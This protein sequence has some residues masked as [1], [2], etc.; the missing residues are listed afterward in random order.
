MTK[1][2]DPQPDRRDDE[3]RESVEEDPRLVFARVFAKHDRWL[4]AYL[5]TLLGNLSHAEEV[6][7]D[8]CVVLWK[9][10]EKFDPASDF[11]RWA[12]VIAHNQVRSFRRKLRRSEMPL[13]DRAVELLAEQDERH[14]DLMDSRRVALRVCLEQLSDRDRDLLKQCYS[15]AG[16]TFRAV[17]EQLGRPANTI[18]KAINRIRRALHECIDRKLAAESR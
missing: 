16:V 18:Y 13:T 2:G 1:Q 3:P 4:Y 9:E 15:T 12:S 17:A 11:R 7:Q 6:F 14:W 8:V 5:V 10:N